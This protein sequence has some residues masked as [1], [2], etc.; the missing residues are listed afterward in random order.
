MLYNEIPSM[1]VFVS[2]KEGVRIPQ[3]DNHRLSIS[4]AIPLQLA[5][6]SPNP[7]KAIQE[8]LFAGKKHGPGRE[9]GQFHQQDVVF[10]FFIKTGYF[11]GKGG[12]LLGLNVV[13]VPVIRNSNAHSHT[14]LVIS[15]G[16]SV[17]GRGQRVCGL[18]F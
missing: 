10:G 12:A 9:P 13:P 17:E 5:P 4:P 1:S 18:G 6:S 8:H 16:S 15:S 11:D 3:L 14:G 7:P 2:V